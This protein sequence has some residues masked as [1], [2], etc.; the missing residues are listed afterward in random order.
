MIET[1]HLTSTCILYISLPTAINVCVILTRRLSFQWL[2]WKTK[3]PVTDLAD[4]L[5][6]IILPVSAL[7]FGERA[8]HNSTLFSTEQV[9]QVDLK[10]TCL[11]Q[12]FT[13]PDI[14]KLI[15]DWNLKWRK[16]YFLFPFLILLFHTMSNI[17]LCV[18]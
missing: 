1:W 11:E 9:S 6:V 14:K 3:L 18:V 5:P 15:Q 12:M 16:R 4:S 13:C 2:T 10:T 7:L 8:G 17:V